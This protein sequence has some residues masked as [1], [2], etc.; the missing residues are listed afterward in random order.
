MPLSGN[1]GCGDV[2]RIRP[3]SAGAWL[4]SPKG[5]AGLSGSLHMGE[6]V[7]QLS[8]MAASGKR[9]ACCAV[10]PLR[11]S[12]SCIYLAE[13]LWCSEGG[14][15]LCCFQKRFSSASPPSSS[16]MWSSTLFPGITPQKWELSEFSPW[17]PS[18]LL[19]YVLLYQCKSNPFPLVQPK[20]EAAAQ[21]LSFSP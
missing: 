12:A 21:I 19:K 1:C 7:I 10:D 11:G 9:E 17:K 2:C 18:L 16:L 4:S 14:S 5:L 3:S 6:S 13:L 20:K 8:S 15:V